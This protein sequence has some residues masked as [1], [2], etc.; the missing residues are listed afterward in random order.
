MHVKSLQLCVTLSD[1]MD[2]SPPGSSIQGIFQ[3][4]IL[5]WVAMPFPGA[6]SQPRDRTLISCVSCI[7]RRIPNHQHHLGSPLS[8]SSLY[9]YQLNL[10]RLKQGYQYLLAHSK[11]SEMMEEIETQSY[12]AGAQEYSARKWRVSLQPWQSGSRAQVHHHHA[13]PCSAGLLGDENVRICFMNTE[14]IP[15]YVC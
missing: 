8:Q 9:K 6:S 15:W 12:Q 13:I 4:R 3:A 5:E 11:H 2:C 1:L 10:D 7:G 14:F